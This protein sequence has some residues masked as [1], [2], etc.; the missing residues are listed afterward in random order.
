MV[1]KVYQKGHIIES[2]P[3][4]FKSE[5]SFKKDFS[6]LWCTQATAVERLGSDP[7]APKSGRKSRTNS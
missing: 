2:D 7:I 6:P 1:T 5:Y 3:R 4:S